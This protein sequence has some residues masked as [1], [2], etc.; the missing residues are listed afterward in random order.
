[1][2]NALAKYLL[3][4]TAL[5]PVLG[6]LAVRSL[7]E[8]NDWTEWVPW[9]VPAIALAAICLLLLWLAARHGQR[10]TVTVTEIERNDQEVLAFL[11][12]YLL[13]IVSIQ[14]TSFTEQWPTALYVLVILVLAYT[15]ACALHI[16]PIMGLFGYHFYAV[17]DAN[18][19]PRLLISRSELHKQGDTM[20][21]VYIAP[22]ICLHIETKP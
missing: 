21:I 14:D 19:A 7:S 11:V 16:N 18:S 1:M 8:G 3:V 6:G 22:T 5:A 13:P 2:L 15:H 4:A 10:Q 20:N 9:L 12:A 17:R